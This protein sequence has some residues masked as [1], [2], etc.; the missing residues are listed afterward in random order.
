MVCCFLHWETQDVQELTG[1]VS[2]KGRHHVVLLLCGAF[3]LICAEDG[4]NMNHQ[5]CG[6]LYHAH[7]LGGHLLLLL[8]LLLLNCFLLD[9][10]WVLLEPRAVGVTTVEIG[11]SKNPWKLNLQCNLCL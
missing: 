9:I 3:D 1:D 2:W 7:V 10:P 4:F 6:E 5:V 8:L 11:K